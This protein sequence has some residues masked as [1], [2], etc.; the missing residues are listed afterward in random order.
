M[1]NYRNYL[2]VSAVLF[3]L[4]AIAHCV[5]AIEAWPIAIGEWS[6][7]I[8]LSWSAA[9]VAAMLGCWAATLLRA[10]S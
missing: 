3:A 7:P 5:R 2:R 10:R 8:A 1:T 4:I 6:V 9:V